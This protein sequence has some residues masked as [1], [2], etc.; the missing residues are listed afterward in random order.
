[1]VNLRVKIKRENDSELGTQF[2]LPDTGANI[3]CM[4]EKFVRKYKLEILPD[5][6]QMI[7]L[8]LAE[9]KGIRFFGTTK[10]TIQSPE[11]DECPQLCWC[12]LNS[13]TSFSLV[14]SCRKNEAPT[15]R[16]AI[17]KSLF[18]KLDNFL[19]NPKHPQKA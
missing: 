8:V 15:Q 6:N 2:T 7:E 17:Y 18:R 14:G 1:M 16:L 13:P 19:R 3:D 4:D 12:V 10:L 5:T 9:E 11:G